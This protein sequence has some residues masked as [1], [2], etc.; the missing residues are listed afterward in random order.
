MQVRVVYPNPSV[1]H[2]KTPKICGMKKKS[3]LKLYRNSS[4][5]PEISV[6]KNKIALSEK[7]NMQIWVVNKV[8]HIK[9]PRL[10]LWN[11]KNKKVSY[12][13][14]EGTTMTQDKR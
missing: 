9:N 1:P 12:S 7:E 3:I 14:L 4:K 10:V 8:C 13:G 11:P 5:T 6:I 2:L